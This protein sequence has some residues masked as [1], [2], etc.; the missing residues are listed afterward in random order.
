[1]WDWRLAESVDAKFENFVGSHLLKY[2]QYKQDSDGDDWEL[3]YV[4]DSE[5]RELDFLVTHNS[6][7]QFGVE[8]KSGE[9]NLSQLISID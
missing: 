5:K 3:K 1:M 9:K 7:P 2:V 6:V 4:R 8:C